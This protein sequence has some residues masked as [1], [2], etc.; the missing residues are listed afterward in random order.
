[1]EV[2]VLPLA[3]SAASE[4]I[5]EIK[6]RGHP[7]TLSDALAEH[8]SSVYANHCL[9]EYGA[10]LHH[11]FDKVGLL[12]GRSF[13]S[14]GRGHLTSPVRVQLNG[15]AS[16]SFGQASIDVFGLLEPECRK[17]LVRHLPKLDAQRDIVVA[18]N[19]AAGSSPGHVETGVDRPANRKN[20]FS[21]RS[22]ADLREQVRPRSNDTS[23][24]VGFAPFT[25]LETAIVDLERKLTDPDRQ[26]RDPWLGTD[27]KIMGVRVGSRLRLTMCI[28]QI[29]DH[30]PDAEAYRANIETI[31]A[32]ATR[33]IMARLGDADLELF[34]NTKDDFSI[35]ELY[36]TATGSSIESGD[37]GFVG[38]GNRPSGFIS[39]TRPYSMEGAAGKNPVY[40]VGKVYSVAAQAMARELFARHGG[41]HEV[42][43]VSQEG[44]VLADPWQVI[45]KTDRSLAKDVV[46]DVT[47]AVMTRLPEFTEG[48][49]QGKIR[50]Y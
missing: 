42:W 9:R 26:Q 30:V 27:I 32:E 19:L 31:R 49:I 20:W 7:D 41:R 48:L 43:L 35:P 33:E 3:G 1:M 10:V 44:R 47:E 14:F 50:V 38:R 23:V 17:F 6:G 39:M 11:N 4:E 40:H 22:L 21:P 25:A 12:G 37:E 2:V 45:V 36:L 15:R 34:T 28:P 16:I 46:C 8:L 13:V 29:A 18:N 24:G 5:I